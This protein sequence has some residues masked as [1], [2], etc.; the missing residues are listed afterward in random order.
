M[1]RYTRTGLS[2]DVRDSGPDNGIPVILLHGF[3]QTSTCWAK[4]EPL[5]HSHGIRTIA[6]D[7][8]GYSPGARPLQ[9]KRYATAELMDDVVAL[10]E[11]VGHRTA[12]L[13]GHDWGGALAWS[14]AGRH[15]DRF[16][17]VTVLSTPHP[18]AMSKAWTSS[19]QALKSWYM[20]AFQIPYGPE[21]LLRSDRFQQELMRSGLPE[22]LA[23]RDAR[24]LRQPNAAT[25][26]LNWYRGIPYSGGTPAGVAKLPVTYVWGAQDPFLGRA[27]AEAS[28]QHID[29]NY[30]NDYRF[31]ELDAGHWLP[32]TNPDQVAQAIVGRV[33]GTEGSGRTRRPVPHTHDD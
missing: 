20:G 4:V 27:A 3:P 19:S 26:A 7:Q 8:R 10:L 2:F 15:A 14:L 33:Q 12:H 24:R 18:A 23:R 11:S 1:R 32:E 31:V 22:P 30:R 17:S 13:V 9:R 25:G 21:A 5:L 28:A 16:R 29:A 6:P